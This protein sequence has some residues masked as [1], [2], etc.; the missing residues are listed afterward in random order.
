MN[1]IPRIAV[2][3]TGYW[4]KNLVRNFHTLGAL[5]TICD[6]NKEA[7]AQFPGK[8]LGVSSTSDFGK[9]LS[10]P[11]LRGIVISTPAKTHFDLAKKALLA[12]KDVFVEKPLALRAGEGQ[13]LVRIAKEKKRILMVGHI[14]EYHP[15]VAKIRQ[16]VE[17]GEIGRLR[18]IY[19]HRLNFGKFRNEENILWSFAP[20][21]IAVILRLANAQPY[22]VSA[23]GGTYLRPAVA[24][25]TSTE[26]S[27]K[28]KVK[29]YIFVS[30]LNPFKEQKL[31]IVG[32]RK[33][34]VF[35]DVE[36][37]LTAYGL[38]TDPKKMT[39]VKE[40]GESV[41]FSPEEPLALE[42]RAF[43]SSMESRTPPLTDGKSGL[44]VLKVLEAAQK[45]MTAG[46][47]PVQIPGGAK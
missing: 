36:K 2:A 7:L 1:G 46:G 26:L 33:M 13:T 45:S 40:E 18:F 43:L 27:F 41:P 15:A 10:S 14:L 19:S 4:G 38:Q 9:L 21:D 47:K 22:Q 37:K 34:L 5:E 24:D 8:Y 20:H 11:D 31:V 6:R 29:A 23:L 3:G 35:D 16:M 42:C 17:E 32:S 30:W 44:R 25:V 28:S 39:P 12:G